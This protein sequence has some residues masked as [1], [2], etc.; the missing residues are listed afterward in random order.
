MNSSLI[1]S[2]VSNLEVALFNLESFVFLVKVG[3]VL[4]NLESF[5]FLVKVGVVLFDL[6]SKRPIYTPHCTLFYQFK[7]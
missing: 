1:W 4:F 2:H 7:V 3:V 6:E 5:I